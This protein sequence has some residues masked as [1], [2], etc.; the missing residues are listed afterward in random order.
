MWLNEEEEFET[1]KKR[2]KE[3]KWDVTPIHQK[4]IAWKKKQR[5][6]RPRDP[7]FFRRRRF[8]GIRSGTRNDNDQD[9][10]E[11]TSRQ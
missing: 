9:T 2:F 4:Y 3:R 8:Y 6:R 1:L 10:E 7:L 11:S 5:V